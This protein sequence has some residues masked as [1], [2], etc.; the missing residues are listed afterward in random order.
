M[1][2]WS[3]I[4]WCCLSATCTPLVSAGYFAVA[5]ASAAALLFRTCEDT[6][7]ELNWESKVSPA[8]TVEL[9]HRLVGL[10]LLLYCQGS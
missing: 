8:D 2:N 7:L 4:V 6:T 9:T 10:L 5:V 1:S 3:R